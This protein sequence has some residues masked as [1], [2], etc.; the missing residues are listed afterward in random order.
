MTPTNAEEQLLLKPRE[1]A[2]R[3]SISA[4]QLW[5]NTQ[6]RGPIPVFRIGGCVRYAPEAL[7][8]FIGQNSEDSFLTL[9]TEEATR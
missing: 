7:K 5:A 3:L 8:A 2:A 1:A 9:T 4:R 6:P